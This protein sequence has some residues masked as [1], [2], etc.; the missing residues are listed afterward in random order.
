MQKRGNKMKIIIFLALLPILLFMNFGCK[1][2]TEPKDDIDSVIVYKPN[3]YIY[4]SEKKS[5]TVEVSFPQGG[6]IIESIPAYEN[7]WKVEVDTNGKINNTYDYLFYEC[8][9]PDLFQMENGWIIKKE[10]LEKFFVNNLSESGFSEKEQND[11]I[12]Y[13]IPKLTDNEYYEIYPQYKSSL[14]KIIEINFSLEPDNFYRLFY[15]IKGRNNNIQLKEP[16]IKIAI[17]QNFYS[18][19]WGVILK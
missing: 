3:I 5:L 7:S 1:N 19:E 16:E 12:E 4:P 6:K 13:W 9:V 10:Y 14:D 17:R 8:S 2:S 15:L 11:F 18:V